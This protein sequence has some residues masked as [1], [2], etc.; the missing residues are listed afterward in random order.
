MKTEFVLNLSMIQ[1]KLDLS[2]V[3][4]LRVA[5]NGAQVAHKELSAA[6]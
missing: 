6:K 4:V 3:S 5:L 2:A 1:Y